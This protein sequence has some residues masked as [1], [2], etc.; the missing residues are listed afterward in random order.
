MSRLLSGLFGG[1]LG[2][3]SR[4]GPQTITMKNKLILAFV[5]I[6]PLISCG[7]GINTDLASGPTST[8]IPTASGGSNAACGNI[9]IIVQPSPS[10]SPSGGAQDCRVDYLA[11]SGP[12][13]LGSGQEATFSLTPMQTFNDAQGATQVREVSAQCNEA[14]QPGPQWTSSDTR[15]LSNPTPVN[16]GFE[17]KVKRVGTGPAS[18]SVSFDGKVKVFQVN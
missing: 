13:F 9:N 3:S 7:E 11:G 1:V 10:P 15:I 12:D 16:T 8:C 6:L 17:A 18:V 2:L 5:L 14:R 4:F